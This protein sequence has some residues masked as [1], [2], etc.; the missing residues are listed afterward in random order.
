MKDSARLRIMSRAPYVLKLESALVAPGLECFFS[1]PRQNYYERALTKRLLKPAGFNR[2]LV[3]PDVLGKLL[4]ELRNQEGPRPEGSYPLPPA[5]GTRW[6][7][8]W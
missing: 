6:R 7:D 2:K 3:E 8:N 4:E 1:K 5:T